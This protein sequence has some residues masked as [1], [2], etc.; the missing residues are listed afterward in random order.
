LPVYDNLERAL[1]ASLKSQDFKSLKSGIEMIMKQFEDILK[2]MRVKEIDTK[3][4]FD[5]NYHHVVQK[6]ERDDK[7]D[8]EIL[9]VYQKGFKFDDETVIR[10]AQVK[11]A[12][13]KEK[14]KEEEIKNKN[15]E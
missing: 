12:V 5:Y 6:E 13:K 3:G 11:I 7:E 8:G 9:E 10:P 4:V 2:G 15:K 1:N 14:E